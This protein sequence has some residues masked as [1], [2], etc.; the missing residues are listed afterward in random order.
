MNM[1]LAIV[2]AASSRYFNQYDWDELNLPNEWEVALISSEMEAE[3]IAIKEG[4]IVR[5][6]PSVRVEGEPNSR[7]EYDKLKEI[8][9]ELTK[10]VNHFQIICIDEGNLYSC[11]KLRNYFGIS[12]QC[13]E[14]VLIISD[15]ERAYKK[16]ESNNIRVPLFS[17]F[18]GGYEYIVDSVGLPFI[19]KPISSSG[20]FGI[21]LVN[22]K[23]EYKDVVKN[24]SHEYI[25]NEYIDGKLY[26]CDVQFYSG[27]LIFSSVG[28]YLNPLF[29]FTKGKNIGS[30]ILSQD[31][32]MSREVV[33]FSLK[34]LDGLEIIPTGSYHIEVFCKEGELIFL[35]AANRPPGGLLIELHKNTSCVNLCN[36]DLHI[37]LNIL[38]KQKQK[39]VH[40]PTLT[41]CA[42]KEQGILLRYS[43]PDF[44][45]INNITTFVEH[46]ELMSDPV[47][48]SDKALVIK[49]SSDNYEDLY[50]L[51]RSFCELSLLIVQT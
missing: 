22:S 1:S 21:S 32:A 51:Y 39:R 41:V 35:E 28:E 40:R 17:D 25:A 42:P 23:D 49:A 46:G 16:L 29:E 33:D 2:I 47:S 37:W 20:A 19:I 48:I 24:D 30:F 50:R 34:C 7:F 10:E 12:V 4:F 27:E 5:T 9:F 38:K 13:P 31:E 8:I 36:Q 18:S 44:D 43:I 6:C 14:D 11:A 3:Q 26:H 15:K 45:I